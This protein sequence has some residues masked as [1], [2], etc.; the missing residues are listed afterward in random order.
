LT[1]RCAYRQWHPFHD[2]ELCAAEAGVL[3]SEEVGKGNR[4]GGSEDGF[5][6]TIDTGEGKMSALEAVIL[7]IDHVEHH[8]GQAVVYLRFKGIKPA[9]YRF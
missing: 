6:R 7:L 5:R 1:S 9:D 3:R 8:R 2:E 4:R